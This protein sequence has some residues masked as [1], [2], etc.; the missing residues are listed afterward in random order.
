MDLGFDKPLEIRPG[1]RSSWV[2]RDSPREDL[3]F[4]EA[5]E[6][7]AFINVLYV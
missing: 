4:N 1:A 2:W 3:G 5:L 7:V 6:I